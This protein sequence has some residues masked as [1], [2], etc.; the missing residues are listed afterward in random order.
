MNT[1]TKNRIIQ[2][3]DEYKDNGKWK[4]VPKDDFGLQIMFSKYTEVRRPSE[5]PSPTSTISPDRGT[6]IPAKAEK[7]NAP[8]P[9][10]SGAGETPSI[11]EDTSYDVAALRETPETAIAPTEVPERVVSPTPPLPPSVTI[12][13]DSGEETKT[14][15]ATVPPPHFIKIKYPYTAP[16]CI[17]TGRNGTFRARGLDINIYPNTLTKT[18]DVVQM[19]PIG[20]RG[21]AKNAVIEFPACIIPEVIDFLQK[22][23][24]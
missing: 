1:L 10:P 2:E 9:T 21:T 14:V 17:W 12:K 11:K 3:G 5:A 7:V 24:H 16:S 15:M 22:Q 18:D 8:A 4:A 13:S 20:K 23:L 19:V 6:A